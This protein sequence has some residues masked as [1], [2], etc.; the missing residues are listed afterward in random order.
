MSNQDVARRLAAE[1]ARAAEDGRGAVE[2]RAQA[3]ADQVAADAAGVVGAI[4]ADASRRAARELV[5]VVAGA[6]E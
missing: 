3:F 2:V 1:L 5:T 6:T 4:I